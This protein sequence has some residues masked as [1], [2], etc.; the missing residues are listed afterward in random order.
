[1]GIS[2]EL[3]LIRFR[4]KFGSN[5]RHVL[6][7]L[8]S[9]FIVLVLS[10]LVGCLVLSPALPTPQPGKAL[11]VMGFSTDLGG[12]YEGGTL[13]SGFVANQLD[14]QELIPVLK[15]GQLR[16][17]EPGLH[18][19]SGNCYWRLR[20]AMDLQDDLMEP[21]VVEWTAKPGVVYTVS[22]KIDEYK[23]K[24]DLSLVEETWR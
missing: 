14:K 4:R 17:I 19:L 11:L 23:I 7:Q 21:G 6:K 22:S 24:C 16:V 12:P 15:G 2:K 5:R 9:V 20:G 13:Y 8:Y 1:M 3:R 10:L 18:R